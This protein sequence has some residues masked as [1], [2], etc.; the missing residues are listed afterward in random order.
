MTD[1]DITL[2][3]TAEGRDANQTP[4]QEAM[5]AEVDFVFEDQDVQDAARIM[6]DRQIRRLPVL[7]RDRQLVG[8]LALGDLS[9]TGD[10]RTSGDTLQK[11]SEPTN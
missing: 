5:T 10:D 11:S 7:G 1:R 8:I 6:K 9:Q 4:V 3:I 2:R